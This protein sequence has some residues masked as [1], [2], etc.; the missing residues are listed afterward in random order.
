MRALSEAEVFSGASSA[1]P[2][3]LGGFTGLLH[4]LWGSPGLW[5]CRELSW[6]CYIPVC[7]DFSLQTQAS[8][9]LLCYLTWKKGDCAQTATC[10]AYAQLMN[11]MSLKLYSRRLLCISFLKR[12][13]NHALGMEHAWGS[14]GAVCGSEW[15][16][17]VCVLVGTPRGYQGPYCSIRSGTSQWCKTPDLYKWILTIQE[18]IYLFIYCSFW[19]L[20]CILTRLPAR[21]LPFHASN[22]PWIFF[23]LSV[24]KNCLSTWHSLFPI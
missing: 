4:S 21:L 23:F 20:H 8:F 15:W 16:V 6:Y 13:R 17:W 7:L 12:G 14:P 19:Y 18:T 22:F 2:V 3:D 1:A 5:R 10:T 24:A 11:K 9:Y